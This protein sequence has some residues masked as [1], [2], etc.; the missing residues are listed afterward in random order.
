MVILYVILAFIVGLCL[1]SGKQKRDEPKE[2]SSV[3][4]ALILSRKV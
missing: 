2:I 4:I 1:A 3:H